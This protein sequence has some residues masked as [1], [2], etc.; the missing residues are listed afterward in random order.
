MVDFQIRGTVPILPIQDWQ[1]FVYETKYATLNTTILLIISIN[2]YHE[3]K[4]A[5][6]SHQVKHN[7]LLILIFFLNH[8]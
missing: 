2:I 7:R 6:D 5:F 8:K 3:K 4:M 1:Q